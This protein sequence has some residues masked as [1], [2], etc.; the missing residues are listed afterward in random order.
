MGVDFLFWQTKFTFGCCFCNFLFGN[1]GR[2]RRLPSVSYVMKCNSFGE[3][4]GF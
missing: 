4:L 1:G 2:E 3:L